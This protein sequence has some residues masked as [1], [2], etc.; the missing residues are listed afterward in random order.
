MHTCHSINQ[1]LTR[2]QHE[3]MMLLA[4]FI[5]CSTLARFLLTIPS[6]VSEAHHHPRLSLPNETLD[7]RNA[8]A[9]PICLVTQLLTSLSLY[10]IWHLGMAW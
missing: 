4:S 3:Y 6:F 1:A 2:G 7:Q 10:T 8:H 9:Q 5:T